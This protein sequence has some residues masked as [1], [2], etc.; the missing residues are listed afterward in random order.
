MLLAPGRWPVANSSVP[1]TSII[2]TPSSI[3]SLTSDGSTSSIWLLIWRRSS[4]PDRL[5]VETP[6]P[7]SEFGDFKKCSASRA[8][9]EALPLPWGDDAPAPPIRP[10]RARRHAR[11]RLRHRRQPQ[12]LLPARSLNRRRHFS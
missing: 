1:R 3:S 8:P 10:A 2:V 12:Q 9:F 7:R 11:H 4:A 5:I 6:E